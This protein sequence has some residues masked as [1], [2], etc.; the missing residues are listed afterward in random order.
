MSL[1]PLNTQHNNLLLKIFDLSRSRSLFRQT[2]SFS[3]H[4]TFFPRGLPLLSS[5]LYQTS[6]QSLL[7]LAALCLPIFHLPHPHFHCS[8]LSL[9]QFPVSPDSNPLVKIVFILS[10]Y[11]V[12]TC[13]S[14][15]S[16]S[17]LLF[18]PLCQ[19]GS[20]LPPMIQ[21][22][23]QHP[24]FYPATS[25]VFIDHLMGTRYCFKH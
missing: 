13:S 18:L 16:G 17:A 24:F 9:P 2:R 10:T 25:Q 11:S 15:I 7:M 6:N 20:N 14:V 3:L 1:L 8:V 23:I 19:S 22:F 21:P 4:S 5:P 12:K